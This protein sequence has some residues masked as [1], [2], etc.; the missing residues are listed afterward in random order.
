MKKYNVS[1]TTNYL[2]DIKATDGA[3]HTKNPNEKLIDRVE[4]AYFSLKKDYGINYASCLFGRPGKPP[5][6]LA[7]HHD[8]R[9]QHRGRRI[10]RKS[11]KGR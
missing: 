5:G 6:V 8:R 1:K 10:G 9:G 3:Q 11:S 2:I 4:Q 7:F